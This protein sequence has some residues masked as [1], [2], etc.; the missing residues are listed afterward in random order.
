MLIFFIVIV[1]IFLLCDYE[2]SMVE[3]NLSVCN[4]QKTGNFNNEVKNM[5]S[6]GQ[7]STLDCKIFECPHST[8]DLPGM[9]AGLCRSVS[10]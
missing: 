9:L 3:I 4:I 2:L 1:I 7:V 6:P 5:S 8:F 10:A